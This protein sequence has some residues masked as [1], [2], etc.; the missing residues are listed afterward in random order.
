MGQCLHGCQYADRRDLRGTDTSGS[1][2]DQDNF[3]LIL[4]GGN[5]A[6]QHIEKRI[7]RYRRFVID[8]LVEVGAHQGAVIGQDAQSTQ[9]HTFTQVDLDVLGTKIQTLGRHQHRE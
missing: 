4:G 8:G 7:D 3:V 6:A 1:R 2:T 5:F 9:R